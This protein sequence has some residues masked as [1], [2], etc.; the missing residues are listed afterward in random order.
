MTKNAEVAKVLKEIGLYLEFEG[1]EP[2]KIRAY[3]RAVRS[4]SSLGEDVASI[5]ARGELKA[6]QV[7]ARVLQRSLRTILLTDRS[8][9][10]KSLEHVFQ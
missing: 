7:L 1:K 8:Q 6:F 9:F 4:I 2:F 5:A 10:L 3:Q